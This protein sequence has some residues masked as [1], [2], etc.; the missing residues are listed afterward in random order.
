MSK[1]YQ[2]PTSKDNQT[3]QARPNVA[4]ETTAEDIQEAIKIDFRKEWQRG[5]PFLKRT[6]LTERQVLQHDV[7]LTDVMMAIARAQLLKNDQDAVD[8]FENLQTNML[9]EKNYAVQ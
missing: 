6:G 2:F 4:G 3:Y 5:L 7:I 9:A 1:I 8:Y